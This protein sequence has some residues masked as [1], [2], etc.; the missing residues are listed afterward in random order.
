VIVDGVAHCDTCGKAAEKYAV[1]RDGKLIC[2]PCQK[3]IE[4]VTAPP[5]PYQE[6]I[7]GCWFVVYTVFVVSALVFLAKGW[8]PTF[9]Y[10]VAATA[11]VDMARRVARRR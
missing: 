3:V 1:W 4:R 9:L 5:T 7:L 8:W 11:V 2:R 10:I 6:F